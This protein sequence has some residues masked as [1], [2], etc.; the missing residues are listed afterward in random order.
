EELRRD[1]TALVAYCEQHRVDVVNVTPTYAH[2]LIEEGL[3]EGHRPPLVLL[4][5]EAVTETVWSTLRDTEGTYGYNLYGPTEYTINTLGGGTHDSATPTVGKPIRATRA[6]VLDPWLRPVP[7]G[8]AGELYIAGVGL[9]RGYLNRPGL[10]AE[11]FVADPYGRPGRSEE[12][13]GG[14]RGT[15]R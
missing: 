6:R 1:A 11:R 5:G 14:R 13:R 15:C 3:L 10:T 2:L 8:V 4:G 7:D 12:R 9:A